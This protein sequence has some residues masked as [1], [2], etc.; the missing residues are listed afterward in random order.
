MIIEDRRIIIQQIAY[1]L[2]V[3]ACFVH[4]I[5]QDQLHMAKVSSRWVPHLLTLDQRHEPVQSCQE[6]LAHYSAEEN[7]FLFRT[8]TGDESCLYCYDP[9]S[10]QL[11]KEWKQ[12][13]SP[14]PTKLEQEKSADKV[15]YSFFCNQ[16]LKESTPVGIAITKTYYE[17]IL[18]NKLHPEI[19][20]QW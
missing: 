16:N 14:P 20:K 4:S 2:N 13:D 6:L 18:V 10:K 11:S 8:I 19:K 15:L 17:D 12:A 9:E 7:D 5:I 3:S 1:I